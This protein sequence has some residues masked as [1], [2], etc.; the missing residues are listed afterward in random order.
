MLDLTQ[1]LILVVIVILTTLLVVIGIQVI[2]ILRDIRQATKR[3]SSMLIHTENLITSLNGPV[4][5]LTHMAEGLRQGV[6][7]VEMVTSYLNH[8]KSESVLQALTD[9][10]T[11]L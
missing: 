11:Q 3:L 4:S 6:K 1:T 2:F 5:N 10:D 7:A 8:K 9:Q